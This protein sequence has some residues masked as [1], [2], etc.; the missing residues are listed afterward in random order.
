[1]DSLFILW[2]I[3]VEDNDAGSFRV[4][5]PFRENPRTGSVFSRDVKLLRMEGMAGDYAALR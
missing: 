4:S 2:G 5:R 1:M 3:F